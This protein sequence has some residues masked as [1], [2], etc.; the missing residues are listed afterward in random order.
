MWIP[1]RCRTDEE[2]GKSEQSPRK[3]TIIGKKWREPWKIYEQQQPKKNTSTTTTSSRRRKTKKKHSQIVQTH[4]HT[5]RVSE[6]ELMRYKSTTYK[7]LLPLVFLVIFL[8]LCLFFSIVHLQCSSL[9]STFQ[10]WPLLLFSFPFNSIFSFQSIRFGFCFPWRP[11]K[12]H[13]WKIN[14]YYAPICNSR[15]FFSNIFAFVTANANFHPNSGP[16][17]WCVVVGDTPK[18]PLENS[19]LDLIKQY[20]LHIL[21]RAKTVNAPQPVNEFLSCFCQFFCLSISNFFFSWFPCI[22]THNHHACKTI[23]Y[24][25]I[26]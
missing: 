1:E 8:Y 13:T 18:I 24:V 14:L 26:V 3:T 6:R 10:A 5:Q 4:T 22:Q 19:R 11:N 23:L 25:S 17:Y 20:L 16:F 15:I 21:S 12:L 2:W 7:M 9:H